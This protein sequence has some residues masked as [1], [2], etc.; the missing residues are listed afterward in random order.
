MS[1]SCKRCIEVVSLM[2]GVTI[3]M[4]GQTVKGKVILDKEPAFAANVFLRNHPQIGVV[5][6]EDGIFELT[7]A[8]SL[9]TD[10]IVVHILGCQDVF[11]PLADI[12]HFFTIHMQPSQYGMMLSEIVVRADPTASKEFAVTR[13]DK[14]AIY[15]NPAS[16]ADPLRAIRLLPYSTATEESA[17]PELRGSP[18]NL[19]CV[20]INGVPIKNPVRNQQLNGMGN[21]SL[22]SA[23]IVG[24]QYIYPS[25][26][27]LEWGNCIGGI[28]DIRTTED[29]NNDKET[30]VSLSLANAGIFHSHRIRKNTF[31]QM[32][33]NGQWSGIYKAA[34]P[35]GLGYL[36]NFSSLDGG[37]NFRTVL[38][39][40]AYINV[41]IY[42]INEQYKAE[43][44]LYN[45]YG[46]QQAHNLR[47]FDIINYRL[48]T[49]KGAVALNVGYDASNSNYN[50][51]S[52]RDTTY[53]HNLFLSASYKHYFTDNLSVVAGGDYEYNGYNYSGM[54]PMEIYF[55]S[56][57]QDAKYRDKQIRNTKTEA[58]IYGKWR[59]GKVIVGLSSRGIWNE[60][61]NAR[62]SYQAN[63]KY[64]I[65]N[66]Q[67][68]IASIGK[69][70]ALSVPNYY[71]LQMAFLSSKQASLDWYYSISSHCRL[72]AA[73]YWKDNRMPFYMEENAENIFA[74]NKL[75]GVEIS[76]KV[77]WHKI[78]LNGNYT[79]LRSRIRDDSGNEYPSDNDFGNMF[80]A[81]ASF[82]DAKLFNAAISFMYRG[83]LHYTPISFENG[84]IKFGMP[85]SAQYA[86]YLTLDFSLN[87]YIQCK[88]IGIIPYITITNITNR[89]NQQYFYYDISYRKRL[90]EN[91]QRRLIYLGCT[92]RF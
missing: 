88:K 46:Y 66:S 27:P 17:N 86:E 77:Q 76:G 92:L 82:T 67:G 81:M 34:N 21:F 20:L 64:E 55:I 32:Y 75:M 74:N 83:G 11:T 35:N 36:D 90:Q 73:L 61:M 60:N 85:N 50:Y 89:A 23:D 58:F 31:I 13:L 45:Y 7:L 6:G 18:G 68:L 53:Q 91:Y 5:T 78:E 52:I 41:Y 48:R 63:V 38:S 28:V 87:K 70:H 65:S 43:K 56:D 33:G 54:Y 3:T 59:L 19:S 71:F 14:S 2:F 25:N 4:C 16:G 84:S 9:K 49:K 12:H 57:G 47:N 44:G 29:L 24:E 22:F 69:Y 40:K 42:L 15:L 51:G 8:D 62:F 80:K 37:F 1:K 30:S 72:G 39:D 10:T 79:F 26:P